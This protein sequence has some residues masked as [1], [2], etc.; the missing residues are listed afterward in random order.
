MPR[1]GH[2]KIRAKIIIWH[3]Y[4]DVYHMYNSG[5]QRIIQYLNMPSVWRALIGI[6]IVL[7]FLIGS[8]VCATVVVD[9][10]LEKMSEEAVVVVDNAQEVVEELGNT[11][12]DLCMYND[13]TR[14]SLVLSGTLLSPETAFIEGNV[15]VSRVY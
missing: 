3:R 6:G 15:C 1:D 12:L 9:N 13:E 7:L 4:S 11:P 10:A 8:G 14:T 5:M 2:D